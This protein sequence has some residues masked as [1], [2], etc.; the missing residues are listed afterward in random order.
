MD[1]RVIAILEHFGFLTRK[2]AEHISDGIK[3]SIGSESYAGGSEIVK[4]IISKGGFVEHTLF[5]ELVQQVKSLESRVKELEKSKSAAATAKV[6]PVTPAKSAT[7]PVS[8]IVLDS[9]KK[10]S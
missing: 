2:E 6:P 9:T 5:P 1:N 4:N 10:T 3:T 7:V 8:N